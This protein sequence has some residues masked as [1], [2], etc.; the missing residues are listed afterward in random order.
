[1]TAVQLRRWRGVRPVAGPT[2]VTITTRLR[3]GSNDEQVLDLVAEHLGKLRRAD[4]A[5]IA[6]PEPL[7]EKID[8]AAK[9]RARRRRVNARKKA[10]TAESSARWASA[11]IT[12]NDGQYRLARDAQRR[13]IFGLT[14]AIRTIERRIAQPTTDTLTSEQHAARRRAKLRPGYATQAERFQKQRR[15]Q[16]LRAE[17]ERVRADYYAHRVRVLEGGKRLAKARNNLSLA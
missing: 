7:D 12:A 16:M 2:G 14:A 15:L 10:L 3:I 1:M 8:G 17:L 11:I 4:L 9:Q 6:R 5:A 13:H